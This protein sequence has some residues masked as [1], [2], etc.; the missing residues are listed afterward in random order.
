MGYMENYIA[1]K[2]SQ[3]VSSQLIF[4]WGHTVTVNI[5]LRETAANFETGLTF[6]ANLHD[7]T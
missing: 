2:A 6:T 7:Y 5:Y 1:S 4:N 3:S